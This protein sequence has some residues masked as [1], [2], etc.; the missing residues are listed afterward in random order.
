MKIGIDP[1][2]GQGHQRLACTHS[3]EGAVEITAVE[4]SLWTV[5]CRAEAGF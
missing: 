4:S 2:D 1:N 3:A 5:V